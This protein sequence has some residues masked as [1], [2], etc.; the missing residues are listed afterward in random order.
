[1]GDVV[2]EVSSYNEWDPL[3]ECVVGVC[4]DCAVGYWTDLFF[5]RTGPLRPKKRS[6]DL[7]AAVTSELQGVADALKHEGVKVVRPDKID[8]LTKW[9]TPDFEEAGS[10]GAVNPR[11]LLLIV[12]SEIIEANMGAR[13]RFFEY[14]PYRN[15]VQNY[16]KQGARWTAAPKPCASDNLYEFSF[17]GNEIFSNLAALLK[18][19]HQVEEYPEWLD[20]AHA[21]N[22]CFGLTEAE[23][24]FD[25]ADFT[26]FG[27]DIF[28]NR[29][30]MTNLGG[31][32]WLRRHLEPEY[33][34]HTLAFRDA[35]PIHMDATFVPIRP[36]LV[37]ASPERY[38]KDTKLFTMND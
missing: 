34:V 15:L 22:E 23:P 11:D 26:R 32:E 3:E 24:V 1:M 19:R 16:W 31:I 30:M 10:A 29:S 21:D 28:G 27:K 9:S 2:G 37:I 25:A 12:G 13:G 6:P 7:L 17:G 38:P 35:C 36:G 33:R 18:K 20:K 5:P 8:V 14:R 4:S